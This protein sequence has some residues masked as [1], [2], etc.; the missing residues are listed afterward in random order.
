MDGLRR[1][2][3]IV[4]ADF[5]ERSRQTRF[6]G[7]LAAMGAGSCWFFPPM[8]AGYVT[9]A[10]GDARGSYSSA[11]IG[12]VLGMMFGTIIALF[13]F[14]IVRGTLARDFETRVW[15]LLVA[16]PM[17]R[18]GYLLAKW[19]SHMLVLSMMAAMALAVGVAAQWHHGESTAFAPWE[20]VKP[21][22]VF[23]L[24]AMAV[25]AF[26]AILFDLL[27]WL[28]RSGGN[29]L[30][31]VVWIFVFITLNERLDPE[32]SAWAAGTWLSDPGGMS[33]AMRDI[34][35][36]LAATA[37]ALDTSGFS[38]GVNIREDGVA[39]FAWGAWTP[40][41]RDLA[42]RGLWL[43]ASLLGL[44]ALAPLLDWAAACSEARQP[45]QRSTPGLRLRWLD[46]LLRPLEGSAGGRLFAAE[47]KLVLRQRRLTWWL[48][49]G[50][51]L[52]VQAVAPEKGQAIA[53][54]GAW[55]LCLDLFARAALR[56]YDTGTS[57]LVFTASG[58]AHRVLA[59]RLAVSLSLALL[60]VMPALLRATGDAALALAFAAGTVAVSG[61]ALATALRSP[62]P[63]ELAM[64]FI[65]YIGV[66]GDPILNAFADPALS[67]A[68]HAWLLPASLVL[69]LVAWP[70]AV[71]RA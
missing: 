2:L 59:V 38:I 41:L 8:D 19:S 61:L 26:F 53:A 9:V 36:Q 60:V 46:I 16:T 70:I 23:A 62:R 67:L 66:Q 31:F 28:R 40:S 44:L 39:R 29:V 6:W 5:R 12:M 58:A 25:T 20:L 1:L 4:L 55:L 21:M 42:G 47:L 49:L 68:R 11:W 17:T 35:G 3:A 30:Y 50:V 71:R 14:Y 37:P 15:Q 18:T 27:P 33:M 56:E 48:A 69:L 45:G 65:A 43:A 54:I 13:G 63:F 34:R 52:V 10:I 57:A 7:L 51:L 64:V 32:S 22:L 24:P